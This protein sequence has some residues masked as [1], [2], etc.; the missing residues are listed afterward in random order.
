MNSMNEDKDSVHVVDASSGRSLTAWVREVGDDV[1]VAVGGG[2][3]PHV[4]CVVLAVP[5]PGRGASGFAPSSSVLTI[6][7]HKEEPIAR[8]VAECVCRRTGRVTVVTAGVH[9]DDIDR[10]GIMT[11][12]RLG[13]ELADAVAE[14]LA[15]APPPPVQ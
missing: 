3:R 13:D 14:S 1:V 11:Y 2:D 12:L 4:G 5:T 8:A 15:D 6:P 9:E 10:V 7:P